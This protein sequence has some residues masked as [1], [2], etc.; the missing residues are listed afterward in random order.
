MLSPWHGMG[1]T[2][3]RMAARKSILLESRPLL[4]NKGNMR[5]LRNS[6]GPVAPPCGYYILES[7][8]VLTRFELQGDP[9]SKNLIYTAKVTVKIKNYLSSVVVIQ[10]LADVAIGLQ[11]FNG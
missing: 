11:S 3:F 2:Q 10:Y 5:D 8:P 9:P 6:S 1:F 7:A 4:E